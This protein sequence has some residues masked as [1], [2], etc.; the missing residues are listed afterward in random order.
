MQLLSIGNLTKLTN[1]TLQHNQLTSLPESMTKLINLRFLYLV[2]NPI[3]RLEKE[4]IKEMLPNCQI[5]YI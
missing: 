4:K 1:L 3:S 5:A 2:G